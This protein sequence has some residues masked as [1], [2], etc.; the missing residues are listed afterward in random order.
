M[1]RYK[2]CFRFISFCLFSTSTSSALKCTQYLE[3]KV[4]P[5]QWRF[6][7]QGHA[8][9]APFPRFC[10]RAQPQNHSESGTVNCNL[11]LPSFPLREGGFCRLHC[12]TPE[13]PAEP[14]SQS[15]DVSEGNICCFSRK[16]K[17]LQSCRWLGQTTAPTDLP[18]PIS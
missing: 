2:L 1:I 18:P 17:Q 12:E 7:W 11:A 6:L 3:E 14:A 4:L 9:V 15:P 5:F 13:G 8:L 10:A 16:E